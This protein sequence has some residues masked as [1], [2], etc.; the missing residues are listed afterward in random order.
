MFSC[1]RILLE[2]DRY[3]NDP[4]P[5]KLLYTKVV[6]ALKVQKTDDLLLTWVHDET[7]WA[8]DRAIK[9]SKCLEANGIE[10]STSLEAIGEY[11]NIVRVRVL[12]C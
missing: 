2:G 6:W 9:R 11:T 4:P 5:G 7:Y 10:S 1:L 8:V 3:L 12:V